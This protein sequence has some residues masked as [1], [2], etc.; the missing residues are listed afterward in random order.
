MWRFW[1][2]LIFSWKLHLRCKNMLRCLSK[3]WPLHYSWQWQGCS[4]DVVYTV[5]LQK[6]ND[7]HYGLISIVKRQTFILLYFNLSYDKNMPGCLIWTSK[8]MAVSENV[9]LTQSLSWYFDFVSHILLHLMCSCSLDHV[10]VV[11]YFYNTSI[12]QIVFYVLMCHSLV[13]NS[14]I[15]TVCI[16]FRHGMAFTKLM[17]YKPLTTCLRLIV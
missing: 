12:A 9:R 2:L 3:I 7:G 15:R 11:Y 13:T 14:L 17:C 4:C 6:V 16:C 1:I 8:I 10:I 5:W